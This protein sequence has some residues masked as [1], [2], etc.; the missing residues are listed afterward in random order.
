MCHDRHA[1]NMWLLSDV[2]FGLLF[3]N[4]YLLSSFIQGIIQICE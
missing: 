4:R 3:D 2:V 1:G